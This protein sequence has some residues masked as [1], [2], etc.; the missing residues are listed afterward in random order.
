MFLAVAYGRGDNQRAALAE[1]I[2]AADWI[3]HAI[4][5]D[6]ELRGGLNRLIAAGLVDED[7]SAF[8]LTDSGGSLLA[9]VGKCAGLWKQWERLE[10]AF[11]SLVDPST[12]SW[13]PAEGE[14]DRAFQA[15]RKRASEIIDSPAA[16]R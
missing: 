11:A 5:L 16:D 1:L 10:G 9:K 12:P 7:D 4:P 3:N 14:L 15:Y 2:G 13:M 8:G 6:E